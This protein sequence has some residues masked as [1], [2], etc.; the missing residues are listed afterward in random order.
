MIYAPWVHVLFTGPLI[1]AVALPM[2]ILDLV[3]GDFAEALRDLSFIVFGIVLAYHAGM[4]ME[5]EAS[6][7]E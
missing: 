1:A 2:L 5:E 6:R 3:D 7:D 4:Q